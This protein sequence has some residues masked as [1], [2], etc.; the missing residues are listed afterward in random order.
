MPRQVHNTSRMTAD[1]VIEMVLRLVQRCEDASATQA[2]LR[3][4][5]DDD[6]LWS[7]LF[8]SGCEAH[9]LNF[10]HNVLFSHLLM[11]LAAMYDPRDH[12]RDNRASLPSIMHHLADKAVLRQ[13]VE[14]ARSRTSDRVQPSSE[15]NA[16]AAA[17][18]IMRARIRYNALT[19]STSHRDHLQRLRDLRNEHGAHALVQSPMRSAPPWGWFEELRRDSAPIVSHLCF[20]VEGRDPRFDEVDEEW[21][22]KAAAFW[23]RLRNDLSSNTGS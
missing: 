2:M 19:A 5:N 8:D 12:R 13:L 15:Q 17:R 22:R 3:A 9:G 23:A 1:R 20:A 18:S 6:V 10:V 21:A 4:I 7:L 16:R 14:D 11:L